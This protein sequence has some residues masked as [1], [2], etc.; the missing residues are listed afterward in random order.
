MKAEMKPDKWNTADSKTPHDKSAEYLE[1]QKSKEE[2][3]KNRRANSELYKEGHQYLASRQFYLERSP[4]GA[5]VGH[6]V[7]LKAKPKAV[8]GVRYPHTFQVKRILTEFKDE[9]HLE[10]LFLPRAWT[11]ASDTLEFWQEILD[12]NPKK[13]SQIRAY[14]DRLYQIDSRRARENLD[15]EFHLGISFR[16]GELIKKQGLM[17]TPDLLPRAWVPEAEWFDPKIRELEFGDIFT[18]W[19]KWEL[20]MLQLII[21]RVCVGRTRHIPVGEDRAIQHTMRAA[22]LI[23]GED[24][25]QGKSVT[26]SYLNSALNRVGFQRSNFGS[27]DARFNLAAVVTADLAYK[28][29]MVHGT[30][31]SM[32]QSEATK[33]VITNGMIR[34]ENKFANAV[35]VWSNAVILCNCNEWD[36][37][38]A[39]GLDPGIIDRFK[40]ISTYSTVELQKMRP[41]YKFDGM[42]TDVRPFIWLQ[43]LADHLEVE[44]EALMLWACR[45][46]V[47]KFVELIESGKR[48]ALEERVKHITSHLR[49]SFN[50]DACRQLVSVMVFSDMV[51]SKLMARAETGEKTE[52]ASP[53]FMPELNREILRSVILNFEL[54]A[55]PRETG[56]IRALMK[57][58]WESLERAETHYWLGLRKLKPSSI[59]YARRGLTD[60]INSDVGLAEDVKQSFSRFMLRDG[61]TVSSDIIWVSKAWSAVARNV[62]TLEMQAERVIDQLLEQARKGDEGSAECLKFL[63][64]AGSVVDYKYIHSTKYSPEK[65]EMFSPR[66][67]FV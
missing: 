22:A 54:I 66:N 37:R 18:I 56:A 64:N 4:D 41:R 11:G 38:V 26:F 46:S 39:Y 62:T 58:Q 61:F 10:S 42:P 12:P 52:D 5:H 25:G 53:Y 60:A 33:T 55:A 14:V 19:P 15:D 23:V 36:P 24:P 57:Q 20:E 6:D 51:R 63:S 44:V 16:P 43:A 32:L 34:C 47:D 2:Q 65:A 40:L 1:S 31:K 7:Y 8:R 17:P 29:D 49:I 48:T 21:G 30:M 13:A 59:E 67:Q 9:E 45:L 35:D 3:E 28:D 50:K 27:L